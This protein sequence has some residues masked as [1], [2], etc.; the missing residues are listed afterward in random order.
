MQWIR[1]RN[2]SC[3]II[4]QEAVRFEDIEP[5]NACL[6]KETEERI[7][8]LRDSNFDCLAT[9]N[10]AGAL[11]CSDPALAIAELELNEHV[12]ALIAKLNENEAKDAFAEYARW[13]RERDRACSDGTCSRRPPTP[14]PSICASAKSMPPTPAMIF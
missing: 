12:L 7:A 10:A 3:G 9:N 6:L 1:D 2:S 14:T 5:A 11:I 13:N 8:I 4:G